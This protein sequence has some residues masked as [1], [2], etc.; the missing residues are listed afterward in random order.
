[1]NLNKKRIVFTGG[2]GRFGKIFKE[3]NSNYEIFYPSKS[4]LDVT[5]INKMRSYLK[6]KNLNTL[7]IVRLYQDQ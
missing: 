2:S 5:K 1:M 4:E 7:F 6:K 3:T